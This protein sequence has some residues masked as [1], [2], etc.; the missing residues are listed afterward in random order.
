MSSAK[1]TTP[2][3]CAPGALVVPAQAA[4]MPAVK[5]ATASHPS[6]LKLRV[7]PIWP[8]PSDRSG[9]Q[10]TV[11]LSDRLAPR[12]G[13]VLAPRVRRQRDPS[14]PGPRSPT[15]AATPPRA[16]GRG[17][18]P[19]LLAKGRMATTPPWPVWEVRRPRGGAGW[20]P[21]AR[22]PAAGRSARAAALA[23]RP[24][25]RRDRG[26]PSIGVP[27]CQPPPWDWVPLTLTRLSMPTTM[28][29]ACSITAPSSG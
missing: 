7:V 1:V 2:P 27:R 8:P 29:T 15:T 23:R 26:Q 10:A 9:I 5:V 28:A 13:V 17:R 19:R 16:R 11:G 6:H 21:P 12:F 20:P 25:Q 22:L 3:E 18:P 14:R 24:T 4:T